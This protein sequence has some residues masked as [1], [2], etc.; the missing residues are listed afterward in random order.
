MIRSKRK[1]LLFILA[2]VMTFALMF[3][4]STGLARPAVAQ[5]SAPDGV[6]T[7]RV[8][9]PAYEFGDARYF[10]SRY[11]AADGATEITLEYKVIE[12][13]GNH[14]VFGLVA[15][16]E[17]GVKSDFY[18]EIW[19]VVAA[20]NK[21]YDVNVSKYVA[22]YKL[23]GT[24][25]SLVSYD[26]QNAATT[27]IETGVDIEGSQMYGKEPLTVSKVGI[28]Y[29]SLAWEAAFD[30]KCY[31]DTGKDLGITSVRG[32]AYI[33]GI[34]SQ[35]VDPSLLTT[36][37]AED[38]LFTGG[39][40]TEP[41]LTGMDDL[42]Y[43]TE[44]RELIEDRG[45]HG[46]VA[47]IKNNAGTHSSVGVQFGRA[48]TAEDIALGGKLIVRAW[49]DAPDGWSENCTVQPLGAAADSASFQ[50]FFSEL[51]NIT[52]IQGQFKDIV[53]DNQTLQQLAGD[54][55]E[56]EGL[57]FFIGGWNTVSYTFYFDEIR[58]VFD[59]TYDNNNGDDAVSIVAGYNTLLD[60]PEPVK[61]GYTFNGWY[62][63]SEC[64]EEFD[65]ASTPVT[66]NL[67]L[68]A[69][70][71]VNKY[72]VSFESNG[73][74]TVEAITDV[75]YG[76]AV[77]AP[78]APTKTGYS[79]DKWYSDSDLTVAYDFDA[80]VTDNITLYA[81]WN[82]LPVNVT[83]D[84]VPASEDYYYGDKVIAPENPEPDASKNEYAFDGWYAGDVKWDFENTLSG[85]LNLVSKFKT[86]DIFTGGVD[87]RP[88]EPM[89]IRWTAGIG[90][91]VYDDLVALYGEENVKAGIIITPYDY[92]EDTEFTMA[93]MDAAGIMYKNIV[94]D[95][96][97]AELTA[98]KADGNNYFYG[99]LVNIQQGNVDRDFAGRAYI[100]VTADGETVVYYAEFSAESDVRSYND[101]SAS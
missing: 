62:T 24:Y 22:T 13:D 64:T 59:V 57:Q 68:Y 36:G 80:P 35:P 89:G 63:N 98:E 49:V 99:S 5:E 47:V 65:V 55:G 97:N 31:D 42:L 77:S 18:S 40:R 73:G 37:S 60:I 95:V 20:L 44:D 15:I 52:Y 78:E 79:F 53:V 88:T 21:Y 45:A 50:A 43:F 56:L 17:S 90:A 39:N 12:S 94:N 41:P 9:I 7:Y 54:D 92:I 38:W 87:L 30:V 10:A 75:A 32:D 34:L 28:L 91:E 82:A 11:D 70:Y 26:S 4:A 33:D 14:N 74:S 85:D 81:G 6:K 8:D 93:A 96:W 66:S 69:G 2:A 16:D 1:P 3:G 83:F 84:G 100:S 29:G 101:V 72:T 46:S 71:D 76:T 86:V 61:T 25:A 23:D 48:L 51:T 58:Y 27:L 19:G 67:T